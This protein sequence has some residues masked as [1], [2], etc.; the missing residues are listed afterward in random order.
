MKGPTS[1]VLA[2]SALSL[3]PVARCP[4]NGSA[5]AAPAK[6]ASEGEEAWRTADPWAFLTKPQQNNM[7]HTTVHFRWAG[8]L[9]VSFWLL[10]DAAW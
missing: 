10:R 4:E 3:L 6:K 2:V 8:S 9:A 7:V 1:L 5:A